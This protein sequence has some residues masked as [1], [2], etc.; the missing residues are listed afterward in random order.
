VFHGIYC[1]HWGPYNSTDAPQPPFNTVP[2]GLAFTYLRPLGVG[3]TIKICGI[4]AHSFFI[5]YLQ[6]GNI[7]ADDNEKRRKIA[8]GFQRLKI[9]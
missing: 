3:D 6:H 8:S 9:F 4:E 1:F 2:T 7:G 5:Y